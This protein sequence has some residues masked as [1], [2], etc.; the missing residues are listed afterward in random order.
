MRVKIAANKGEALIRTTALATL[1][2]MIEVT[3]KVPPSPK[4]I[5]EQS[6]AIQVFLSPGRDVFLRKMQMIPTEINM[7]IP[8]QNKM[9]QLVVPAKRTKR[10][11]RLRI[12][13]PRMTIKSPFLLFVYICRLV[14]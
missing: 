11:S 2:C 5:A 3:K 9:F 7:S 14:F 4:K 1:V 12:V 10:E 6:A 8:R 13:T